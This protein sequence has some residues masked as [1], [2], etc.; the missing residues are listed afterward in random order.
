MTPG[1]TANGVINIMFYAFYA[2]FATLLFMLF[3][4]KGNPHVIT[5]LLL[6]I[7]LFVSIKW[8]SIAF[9]ISL[10]TLCI[11][12]LQN[13]NAQKNWKQRHNKHVK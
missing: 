9:S 2:L 10:L 8:Y 1:Y 6:A 3:I 5:F 11:G 12:L 4:T 13:S 7:C